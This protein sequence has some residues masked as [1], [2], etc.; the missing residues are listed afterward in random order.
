[1]YT[2]L[3][4]WTNLNKWYYGVRFAKK[5]KPSELWRTYFTSSKYVK[6]FRLLHGEPDVIQIRKTFLIKEEA[7]QWE[8]KI[9]TKMDVIH[10]PKWL[11]R[12]NNQA[13]RDGSGR[14][15]GPAW[16]KGKSSLRSKESI[17]KQRE[18]ILGKKRGPYYNFNH[19][20]SSTPISFRGKKYI[21]ISDA[22]R[23]TGAA[24]YT[25]KRY[26]TAA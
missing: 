7:I 13:I 6:E 25:I 10:N 3:I 2:Y 4:G 24:F 19:D 12:T 18:T 9:L 5:S 1:M 23:D 20:I 15:Y 26:A 8:S 22:R 14:K 17:D 16:N 11:N 21:S